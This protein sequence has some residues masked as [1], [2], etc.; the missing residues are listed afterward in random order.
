MDA[1]AAATLVAIVAIV[2]FVWSTRK[3]RAKIHVETILGT[4]RIETSDDPEEDV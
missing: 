4:F 3:R 1:T 2:A